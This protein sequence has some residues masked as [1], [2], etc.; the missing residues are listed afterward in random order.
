MKFI[1]PA[2]ISDFLQYR[3]V[4]SNQH[5]LESTKA[6]L[7]VETEGR[8][9]ARSASDT[10]KLRPLAEEDTEPKPP[11]FRRGLQNL[12]AAQNTAAQF[13]CLITGNPKPTAKWYKNG[14]EIFADER[15]LMWLDEY[16]LAR[17]VILNVTSE[18]EAAYEIK[19][20]NNLG[21]AKSEGTLTVLKDRFTQYM[22]QNGIAAA[23]GV[24]PEKSDR[25]APPGFLKQVRNKYVYA[26]TPAIFDAIVSGY[27][28]PS[29]KWYHNGKEVIEND[30]IKIHDCGGGSFALIILK[31]LPQDAGEY[32]CRAMNPCGQAS[33]SANLDV[34]VPFEKVEFGAPVDVSQ[35]AIE[36]ILL[37]RVPYAGIPTPPDR[38]PF[39]AEA[40]D[41]DCIN[42][43]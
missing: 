30:R 11:R 28:R 5:G 12:T 13:E 26:S 43:K 41:H 3:C 9:L 14:Q 38:G 35:V 24:P 36:E 33:S 15:H 20:E 7:N 32:V 21:T 34:S 1:E 25:M 31:S 39:I 2:L 8:G 6:E 18:D 29:V 23:A 4:A 40:T 16:G 17:L 22:E 37:K 19:I 27:P 10:G 42:S